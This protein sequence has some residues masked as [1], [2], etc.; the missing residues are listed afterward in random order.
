MNRLQGLVDTDEDDIEEVQEADPLSIHDKSRELFEMAE[1][2]IERSADETESIPN[3]IDIIDSVP[4]FLPDT[5][6]H[7]PDSVNMDQAIEM[8]VSND[9]FEEMMQFPI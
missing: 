4:V 5:I 9:P 1:E 7:L 2:I 6:A 3:E 8:M